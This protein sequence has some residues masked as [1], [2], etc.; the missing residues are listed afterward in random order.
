MN[1]GM[2]KIREWIRTRGNRTYL[3]ENTLFEFSQYFSPKWVSVNNPPNKS[4]N[5]WVYT[6]NRMQV[7]EY[8]I[9]T[10][11]EDSW[12]ADELGDEVKPDF[13]HYMIIEEPEPPK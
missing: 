8:C 11:Y 10:E 6:D 2:D 4:C 1:I 7:Y 12:W 5:V 3:L 9:C 13:T